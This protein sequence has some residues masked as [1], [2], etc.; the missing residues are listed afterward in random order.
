MIQGSKLLRFSQSINR[1]GL[2][3]TTVNSNTSNSIL[4]STLKLGSSNIKSS[5]SSIPLSLFNNNKNIHK[6][7]KPLFAS[8]QSIRFYTTENNNNET[9]AETTNNLITNNAD[10]A[11]A[12]IVENIT[13]PS[14]NPVIQFFE[15]MN[16]KV[17]GQMEQLTETGIPWL[18]IIAGVA[19]TLRSITLPLTIKSMKIG[20]T[21]KE[22]KE[23]IDVKY[24]HLNDG[25]SEGKLQLMSVTNQVMAQR[26]VSMFSSMKYGFMQMPMIIYP[27]YIIKELCE[28]GKISEAGYLWFTN[29]SVQDPYYI[30]PVATCLFQF[31]SVHFTVKDSPPLMRYIMYSVSFLPLIF[32][33]QFAAGLNV[34][35]LFNAMLFALS[36]Y[37]LRETKLATMVGLQL[38]KPKLTGPVIQYAP[39]PIIKKEQNQLAKEILEKR[40]LINEKKEELRKRRK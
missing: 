26:G 8:S 34:Y 33:V 15:T 25:T 35:W 18:V 40:Q 3:F 11:Q 23:E 22:I 27:F 32:T 17:I 10:Q 38:Y 1:S 7:F 24:A 14:Q 37:L 21:M 20:Q 19:V 13:I 2:G 30:L 31:L 9:L 29:L 39:S 5:S 12:T 36:N 6:A 28:S 16:M 4:K